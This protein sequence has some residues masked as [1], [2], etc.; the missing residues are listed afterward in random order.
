MITLD[1]VSAVTPASALTIPMVNQDGIA[2]ADR[3]RRDVSEGTFFTL[4]LQ[5]K[6]KEYVNVDYPQLK[7]FDLIPVD[8][9]GGPGAE[10]IAYYMFDRTGAA[11]VM[12]DQATDF[13]LIEVFGTKFV[14]QV[15]SLGDAIQYSVQETRAAQMAGRSIDTDRMDNAH[16]LAMR[17]ANQIAFLGDSSWQLVG[18][19]AHANIPIGTTPADGVGNTTTWSTK[20]PDQMLR[21]M[22]LPFNLVR[23]NSKGIENAD[24]LLLPL[25]LYNI[26]RSTPRSAISDKT[27]LQYFLDAN[28]GVT[29]DWLI[30]LETA[31]TV[32]GSP[33]TR[34][35]AYTKDPKKLKQ[36]IPQAFEIFPPVWTGAGWKVNC[37][38]R[39]GGCVAKKPVAAEYLDGM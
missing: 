14:S 22:N 31:G 29:V 10:T 24:T 6:E 30:E 34:I 16:D 2:Y 38:M 19:L 32:N 5:Y 11:K 18:A 33:A 8:T 37:H 28:P 20:T 12:S 21:D 13:P 35:M 36:H 25:S 1:S 7:S 39:V 26:V 17:L 23:Q 4:E 27:V 3:F 9:S 15:R